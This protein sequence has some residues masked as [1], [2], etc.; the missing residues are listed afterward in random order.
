MDSTGAVGGLIILATDSGD[1]RGEESVGY[2]SP[3]DSVPTARRRAGSP[4]R[5]AREIDSRLMSE[6]DPAEPV[7]NTAVRRGRPKSV[8]LEERRRAQLSLA[9]YD[10]FAEVGYEDAAVS[11][12]ARRAGLGQGTLYRYVDGKRELLDLVV[13]LCIERLME[14]VDFD[15]LL[16]AANEPYSDAVK[17]LFADL[18]DRLYRLVDEDPRLLRI[19][20]AQAAAVDPELRYRITSLYNTLDSMVGKLVREINDRGWL[21]LDSD[22]MEVLVRTAPA[23]AVPGLVLVLIGDDD[24]P[25][26]RK[27][28]VAAASKLERYGI[29]RRPTDES[30]GEEDLDG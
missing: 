24:T 22:Q 2:R 29:L 20:T 21:A 27:A 8:G 15:G 28:F 9:A 6:S 13:D 30:R 1:A 3:V 26:R 25:E 23:L 19:L 5:Q 16:D 7:D 4:R 18:G 12:I 10:V 11:E 14:A 17:R